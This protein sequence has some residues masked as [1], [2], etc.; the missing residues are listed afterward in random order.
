M[1]DLETHALGGFKSGFVHIADDDD[2]PPLP[3]QTMLFL[4]KLSASDF[5]RTA[6]CAARPAE[7]PADSGMDKS[8]RFSRRR[9]RLCAWTAF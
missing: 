7:H 5:A 1:D 4:C 3:W 8:A 9:V 2:V 6:K